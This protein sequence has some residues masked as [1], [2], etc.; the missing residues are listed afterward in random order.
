[1]L[2]RFLH[3]LQPTASAGP[4]VLHDWRARILGSILAVCTI[5]GALTAL[6]SIALAVH[7]QRWGIVG[8][9]VLA[10]AT[11]VALWRLKKLSYRWRAGSLV[12]LTYLLGLWF[13]FEIGPASQTYLMAF[14]I[15]AALLLGM[16]AALAALALNA[17]TLMGLGSLVPTDLHL[18]LPGFSDR[19]LLEW[20]VITVNF[21]FVNAV[22]TLACGVLLQRLERSL[23]E[24]LRI[25]GS[26]MEGKERLR[27]TNEELLRTTRA[28]NR[29]AHYDELTGL[30]NRRLLT[31]RLAHTLAAARQAPLGGVLLCLDLDRFK[32]INDGR[33]PAVGDALL[34]AVAQRL[35]RLVHSQDTLARLGGDE[36]A[37]LATHAAGDAET[38]ARAA[39]SLATRLRNAFDEPFDVEGERYA[40][41]ASIGVVLL[42]R[43]PQTADE[44]LRNADTAMHR[45][46]AAGRNRIAFFETAMQQ[47]VEERLALERAL[48]QAIGRGELALHAQ[49]QLDASGTVVGLELLL[50]WQHPQWGSIPPARFIPIAE[51]SHLIVQLGE[52]V[53]EQACRIQR[54]LREAGHA[55]PLAINVSP[56]QFH[57]S[58]FVERVQAVL[59]RTGAHG[60][61]LVFEVTEGMLVSNLERTAAHMGALAALGIRFS[62]DDFGTGYSSLAYLKRLPLH[63]LKIDRSFIHDAPHSANDAAIVTMILSMA[64]HLGL[65]VVAEGV[66]T[67]EQADFL[68]AHGCD[69][70]QG[71]LYAHPEPLD[72]WLA[73][74]PRSASI[75]GEL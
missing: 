56:R 8:V 57:Q 22:L 1:M 62:V 64:R 49:S 2:T 54:Q 59:Q 75:F 11:V 13:L 14:P 16:R 19:P 24:Q 58:D 30:P 42:E 69:A 27:S 31:D 6:P 48:A 46:K 39:M 47:E 63:E 71:F 18:H 25:T 3:R 72:A 38:E 23:Q 9:D 68:V 35:I 67:P 66:E 37:V 36:F 20:A 7:Q 41:S 44:M 53:L 5:L 70:M 34:V 15:L 26:L 12:A 17:L 51:E 10:L 65:K 29:L 74:D 40:I 33:G 50:R 52:W 43:P 32:N 4:E 61:G 21:L 55:L 73:A 28:L 45:A 60:R